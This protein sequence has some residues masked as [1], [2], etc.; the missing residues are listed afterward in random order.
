[1]IDSLRFARVLGS[2]LTAPQLDL[3]DPVT[4]RFRALPRDCDTNLHVNNARY[5]T[6]MDLGRLALVGR[7]GL[8]PSMIKQKWGAIV[9]AVEL[10][11]L[12]EI[13]ILSAFQLTTRI[14]GWDPKWFYMEQRFERDGQLAAVGRV[15]GLFR[16]RARSVPTAEV[17]AELGPWISSPQ[18]PQSFERLAT[19][20]PLRKRIW[21][22]TEDD[23]PG[24]GWA[25]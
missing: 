14:V 21:S 10:E 9:G 12:K 3:S 20:S 15:Q 13:R 7:M 23:L 22:I 18:L 8:G 4:L 6:L 16:S 25:A 11:F 5:L 2:S 24:L 17:I 19:P 1:M